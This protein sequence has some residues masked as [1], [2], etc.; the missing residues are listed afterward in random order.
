MYSLELAL[1]LL[2]FIFLQIDDDKVNMIKP[3]ML[4]IL[5]SNLNS[6]QSPTKQFVIDK[7]VGF[8]K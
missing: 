8:L 7:Q 1:H 2:V 5:K 4:P 6:L 3:V